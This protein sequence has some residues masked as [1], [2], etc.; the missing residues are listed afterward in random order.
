MIESIYKNNY[1]GKMKK[2]FYIKCRCSGDVWICDVVDTFLEA[3]I[4]LKEY[5]LDD[6]QSKFKIIYSLGDN[7]ISTTPFNKERIE[8]HLGKEV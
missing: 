2:L 1:G 8:K 6:P 7:E 5:Q 4:L 3:N